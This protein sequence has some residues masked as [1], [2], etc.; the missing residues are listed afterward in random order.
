MWPSANDVR[1]STVQRTEGSARAAL[2]PNLT[3][4]QETVGW[5]G[6]EFIH[7]F[8]TLLVRGVLDACAAEL[9]WDTELTVLHEQRSMQLG[10]CD[11]DGFV[12]TPLAIA[13]KQRKDARE[14]YVAGLK[15][16]NGPAPTPLRDY[17]PADAAS[18]VRRLRHPDGRGWEVSVEGGK[19]HVTMI[20]SDGERDTFT[21]PVKTGWEAET[22]VAAQL[23][24]GFLHT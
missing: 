17:L 20:D 5:D 8:V 13:E 3:R 4:L 15:A 12:P 11:R 2:T 22:L 10:R 18:A 6:W 9:P 19:M 1:T 14:S 23:R 21:R 16:M 7:G 24:A